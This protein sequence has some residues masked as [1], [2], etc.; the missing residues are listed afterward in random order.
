MT[1]YECDRCGFFYKSKRTLLDHLKKPNAC[2]PIKNDINRTN[3]LFEL[4]DKKEGVCCNFC[5]K[6]FKT[7]PQLKL[8]VLNNID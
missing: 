1:D 7:G 3:I 5:S 4:L 2:M 8:F 6:K